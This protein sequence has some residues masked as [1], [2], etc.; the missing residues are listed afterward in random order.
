MTVL[1][2]GLP[3]LPSERETKEETP[4]EPEAAV[5]WD[6]AE[7]DELVEEAAAESELELASKSDPLL[8]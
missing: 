4:E 2:R 5:D 1:S 6:A 3:L 8:N 7:S